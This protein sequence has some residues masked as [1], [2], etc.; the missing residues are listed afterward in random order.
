MYQLIKEIPITLTIAVATVIVF[1]APGFESLLD[2]QT[3]SPVLHQ[4]AQLFTCHAAHWSFDHL[5]WDLVMFV[6]MGAICERRNSVP[7][8]I[9]LALSAIAIPLF[10]S[11]FSLD[12]NSYRGLSGL[13]TA[14]FGLAVV[15]LVD[16]SIRERNWP[17]VG[18][19]GFLFVG[20]MGKIGYEY[21]AG[22]TLFV[23]SDGFTAV[24]IA[25]LVGAVIGTAIGLFE[26]MRM[27][28]FPFA[29][30]NAIQQTRVPG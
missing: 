15:Y 28:P 30:R 29:W 20:M 7:F 5:V 25:H 3:N 14:L 27:P 11:H 18:L 4:L 8:A 23:S 16:S 21:L 24:P 19:Y 1:L 9:A 13:D 10:V 12:V 2:F 22:G 6:T 26:V 17:G